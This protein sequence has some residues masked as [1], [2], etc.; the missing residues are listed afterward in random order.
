MISHLKLV[1][2]LLFKLIIILFTLF[3]KKNLKNFKAEQYGAFFALRT[4]FIV[5]YK[6]NLLSQQ[7]AT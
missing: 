6:T 2:S 4:N 5:P 1:S 3:V 7:T